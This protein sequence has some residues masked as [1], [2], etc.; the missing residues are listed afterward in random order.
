MTHG[1]PASGCTI[2]V[3][4]HMFMCARH[5]RLVPR[6]LQI[7]VYESYKTSGRLS[8]NHREAVRVVNQA[9]GGRAALGLPPGTKA[10][11]IWQPWASL[12]MLRAKPL[13]FR[14]WNF[15]D[16]PHL[17]KL[18]G[19]RIV[20]HAGARPVRISELEDLLG[21]IDEGE[22]ALDAAIARPFIT[23]L[24]QARRRKEVGAAPLAAALG[25]A[26]LGEPRNVVDIFRDQIADSDR[27]DEHMYGWPLAD[28]E[29]FAAPVPAA[30]AQGFW[31]W[32]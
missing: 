28:A 1:C 15:A 12:V 2:D 17:A 20:V 14:R 25:S 19:H 29:P 16:K 31:N 7:A 11:T 10:F 24:L 32:S 22:S 8:E 21:R 3:P 5:W 13:E 26:V 23:E 6:P 18:I 30:G 9:E 4:S 27:L